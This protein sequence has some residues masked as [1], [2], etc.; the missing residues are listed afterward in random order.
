[1]MV[2]EQSFDGRVDGVDVC[3]FRLL[4]IY[5]RQYFLHYRGY[6]YLAGNDVV[7]HLLFARIALQPVLVNDTQCLQFAAAH[8]RIEQN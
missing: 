1:M 3:L 5:V 8:P 7:A 6:G 4:K 2:R